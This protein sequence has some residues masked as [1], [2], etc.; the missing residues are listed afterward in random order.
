MEKSF[1]ALKKAMEKRFLLSNPR[2]DQAHPL[3][4]DYSD[5]GLSTCIEHVHVNA[6]TI[7]LLFASR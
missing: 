7:Y 5:L 6:D 4:L 1:E 3:S 2:K